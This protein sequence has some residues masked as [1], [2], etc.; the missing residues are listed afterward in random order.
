MA[1]LCLITLPFGGLMIGLRPR[2]RRVRLYLF[3]GGTARAANAGPGPSLVVLPWADL[4]KITRRFDND[5]DLIRCEL[6]G[7]SGTKLVLGRYEGT[8]APRAI[9]W[10]AG[11]VLAGQSPGA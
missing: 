7:H 6:R 4:N 3:E 2:S 9:M 11:Q 1:G 10:A 8:A 5:D